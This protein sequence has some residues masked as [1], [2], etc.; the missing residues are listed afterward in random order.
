LQRNSTFD[1]SKIYHITLIMC[2]PF[3]VNLNNNTFH[4]NT[5]LYF[6]HLRSLQ[7]RTEKVISSYQIYSAAISTLLF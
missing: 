2:T 1:S 5:L 7:K 3:F 6:V 4:L